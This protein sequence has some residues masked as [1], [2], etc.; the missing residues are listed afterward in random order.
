M[1]YVG[2]VTAAHFVDSLAVFDGFLGQMRP[3]FSV[4]VDLSGLDMMELECVPHLTEIMDRCKACGIGTVVRVI[5]DPS[6]DIGFNI[7]SLIHYRGEVRIITC[8]TL[9][10][11]EKYFA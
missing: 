2:T 7:L 3:G 11:A 1:R 10:E 8:E 9:V 6:K 4:L 5:P